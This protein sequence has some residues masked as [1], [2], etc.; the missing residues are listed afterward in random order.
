MVERTP[1]LD[2]FTHVILILGLL[3]A[4]APFAVVAI[5][6]S[7]DLRGVNT[8]PMPL[9]PATASGRTSPAPGRRPI[10]AASSSTAS[11]SPRVSP[12]AR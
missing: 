1:I 6:A 3:T 5:A 2:F 12:P 8:V 7:H 11:S 9:I 4:V 10:S